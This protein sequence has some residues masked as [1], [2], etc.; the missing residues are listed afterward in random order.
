MAAI[1]LISTSNQFP[2]LAASPV[3]RF[4]RSASDRAR[5]PPPKLFPTTLLALLQP[6]YLPILG[7]GR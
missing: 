1:A 3:V 6:T 7:C 5:A 2:A 4:G